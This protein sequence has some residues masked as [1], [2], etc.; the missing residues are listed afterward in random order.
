MTASDGPGISVVLVTP[1]TYATIRRTVDC[2]K[3]QTV[4]ERLELVIVALSERE[5]GLNPEDLEG[6]HGFQVVRPGEIASYGGALAAGVRSA[7]APIVVFSEDH[8]FPIPHWAEAL[9]E[10]H[11]NGWAAVGP[12][13]Y[14][15]NPG[16]SIGWADILIGYSEWLF[17]QDCGE[18][19][20]LPGHNSSYKRHILLEYGQDL[21]KMLEAES[22]LHWDLVSKGYKLYL[23]P[24]A[25]LY[26]LNFGVL[27][28]FLKIHLYM[29]RMFAAARCQSWPK[30][31]RISYALGSLLIPLVRFY[32]ITSNYSG[33]LG[34][35][36]SKP[37]VF[38]ILASGLIA[39]AI[40]EMAG[41]LSGAGDSMQ[42]TFE[43]H[44]HRDLHLK[45]ERQNNSNL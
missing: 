9:I 36:K 19:E 1:D 10:S 4:K 35:L 17:P 44:F 29:G 18:R 8:V 38:P 28:T 23:E 43:Y 6:F 20:H 16:S 30:V 31:R 26:H 34:L 41:Y 42:K 37:Q 12:V 13:V 39:S 3:A 14:N 32:R 22:V 27:T 7:S 5:L 15:A 40:G 21:E 11:K 33:S 45:S 24:E 25:K 2:L